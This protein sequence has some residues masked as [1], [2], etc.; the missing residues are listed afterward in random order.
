M[1]FDIPEIARHERYVLRSLLRELGCRKLQQS[2]YVTETNLM[3]HLKEYLEQSGLVKYIRI[4][5]T[6]YITGI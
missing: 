2:V 5:R 4:A 6:D 1:M 3:D